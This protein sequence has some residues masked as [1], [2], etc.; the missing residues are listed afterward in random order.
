MSFGSVAEV[1][2]AR[3]LG[4]LSR[5]ATIKVRLPKEK[6]VIG[7]G[8]DEYKPGKL[9]E[10]TAGRVIFNDTLPASMAFYNMTMKSKDLSRVISDCYLELGRRATIGLLDRMKENRIPG[11]DAQRS[12]VRYER[13]GDSSQQG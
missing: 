5:H 8:A 2:M 10:T 12:F 11:I 3:S 6:R 9:I 4:R 1:M 13:P 7:E